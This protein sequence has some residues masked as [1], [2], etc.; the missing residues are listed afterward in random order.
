MQLVT[1][2]VTALAAMVIGIAVMRLNGIAA[3]IATLAWL[4]IVCSVFS[5]TQQLT[6]GTAWLVGLPLLIDLPVAT[7]LALAALLVA[8]SVR[9]GAPVR[10]PFVQRPWGNSSPRLS[11]GGA[12]CKSR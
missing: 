5:Y 7:A 10:R 3:S 6:K 2:A 1:I 9:S 4:V 8:V 12:G 11:V